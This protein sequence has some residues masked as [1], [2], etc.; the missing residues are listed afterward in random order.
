[1]L[2]HRRVPVE[3]EQS[4]SPEMRIACREAHALRGRSMA[5]LYL[6]LCSG[7]VWVGCGMDAPDVI[8]SKCRILTDSHTAVFDSMMA[9]IRVIIEYMGAIIQAVL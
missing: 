9:K 6:K 5:R 3:R 2:T 8:L 4:P 1:M 7:A